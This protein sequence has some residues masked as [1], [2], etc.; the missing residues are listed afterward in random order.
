M[1]P[2]LVQIKIPSTQ[3]VVA[4][5]IYVSKALVSTYQTNTCRSSEGKWYDSAGEMYITILVIKQ[6]VVTFS[7]LLVIF[8]LRPLENR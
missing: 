6:H 8:T 5:D 1:L 2:S 7:L 3:K 4:I